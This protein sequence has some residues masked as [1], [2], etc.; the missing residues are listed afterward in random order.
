L[1]T[2]QNKAR[3]KLEEHYLSTI[4]DDIHEK[5]GKLA[6]LKAQIGELTNGKPGNAANL[7]ITALQQRIAT[8][9][10]KVSSA[11]KSCSAINDKL[12]DY[13]GR[14]ELAFEVKS[15][16]NDKA[17]GYLLRRNGEL[18]TG[19]S[20][21]EKT[22]I[23]FAHFSIQLTEQEFDIK[24]GIVVI[25]DPISSLDSAMLFK[26][27]AAIQR[28]LL[29]AG[30]LILLTHNFDFFN[31]MKKW[32]RNEHKIKGQGE[33]PNF[34][35][36]MLQSRFD[37]QAGK[38]VSIIADLDPMLRDYESEYHYLFKA[39]LSFDQENAGGVSLAAIYDYPNLARKL[40]E[41]YLSF[42]IP[43]GKTLYT[44]LHE[45]KNL[46]KDIETEK[47]KYVYEFIN[48][49]SHLNTKDGLLQFDP[50]LAITGPD[51]I[52]ATLSLIELSDE[53]H[54]KAMVKAVG[55]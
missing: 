23:A 10:A 4:F 39:L 32:F 3:A 8:N 28:Q 45:L 9:R 40:L 35:L 25:D 20:E 21:G 26:V 29:S 11:H 46:S 33:N 38:R 15:D 18:A 36:L 2:A 22:A 24:Q 49:H 34:R 27:C 5:D 51:A 37:K 44:Q 42:R 54:Y 7:G 43:T 6:S 13:F 1:E 31:Q 53:K 14:D 55:K 12:R 19:I 41:C 48:S 47:V 16:A 30:Q 17:V 52:K 50:T